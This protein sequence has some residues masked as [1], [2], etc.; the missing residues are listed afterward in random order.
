MNSVVGRLLSCCSKHGAFGS[1]PFRTGTT[2]LLPP[3]WLWF[4]SGR[5]INCSCLPTIEYGYNGLTV[6]LVNSKKNTWHNNY[7]SLGLIEQQKIRQACYCHY[8]HPWLD[9]RFHFFGLSKVQHMQDTVLMQEPTSCLWQCGYGSVKLL[10]LALE[11]ELL[12]S[13]LPKSLR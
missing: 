3:W 7:K 11:D 5:H 9:Q 12:I 8:G 10:P 4:S 13:A 1:L 6:S 2:Q